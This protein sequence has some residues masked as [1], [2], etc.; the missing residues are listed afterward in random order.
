MPL[1]L[2]AFGDPHDADNIAVPKDR[3]GIGSRWHRLP[4]F[5]PNTIFS[6]WP[7]VGPKCCA[8]DL[9]IGVNAVDYSGY[10][11]CR[12]EFI[13]GF[14]SLANLAT[15]SGVEGTAKWTIHA[16][17][18]SLSKSDIIKLGLN[19]GV[20]YS[21]THSCYDPDPDG[22]ACGHCDSC[23]LRLRGF[24]EAGTTDP[25]IYAD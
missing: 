24:A 15:K 6:Q 5:R 8:M 3:D 19:L 22:R 1:D 18:V 10:P 23:Q 21:L 16:P 13:A 12:P 9:F 4:M 2:R 7:W 20:D 17:L 11:D 14:Q 25:A